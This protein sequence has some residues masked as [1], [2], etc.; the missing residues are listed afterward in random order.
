MMPSKLQ[1]IFLMLARRCRELF[2]VLGPIRTSRVGQ[3]DYS[4]PGGRGRFPSHLQ[5]YL[6]HMAERRL[7]M[8]NALAFH[9]MY[10]YYRPSE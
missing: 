4:I 5:V 8:W 1:E 2:P 10:D 3:S 6:I 7:G 9:V